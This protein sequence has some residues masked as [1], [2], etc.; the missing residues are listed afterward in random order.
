MIKKVL[1]ANRGEIAVRIIRACKEMS[2]K[3]V[4]VYSEADREALHV[5]LAD[6]SYCI[7]PTASKDSYLNMANLISVA[8]LTQSDAIHP[9]YGFLSENPDFAEICEECNITFIGPSP[10]AIH[11]MGAKAVARETM[12]K[13]GVPTVPG[14]EGLIN[15]PED[16]LRVA[17]E[18]GYPVI[19]K[20][21]AGGGGKGMRQAYDEEELIKA[22][23][24]AQNEA[25]TAFGNSGVYLEKYL[26]EPRHVEIQI[27]ADKYGNVVHLGERDC[28]IQRRHQK[29]VEEAPSPALSPELRQQM[30]ESAVKAAKAVNYCGAGTVEFLL[31]KNSD[32]YFM[33][34][35][36]R[37]QVEHPV[38]EM[39]T[40]IDLIKEQLS[41]ASGNELSVKQEDIVI[42][43]W[44][45]ECRINAEN[46]AKNF[47][48]SPGKIK[49]YLPPGGFGVRVDSA[50]YPDYEISPFY[51]SMVAKVIVW[52]KDR[53]EA[54]ERMKRALDEMVIKGIK[55]TIPFHQQLLKHEA[56]IKGDFNTTFLERYDL[57]IEDDKE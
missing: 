43:G 18:I 19:V 37:I 1:I 48:P 56:F 53:Q 10:E 13:A 55:T 12:K 15:R 40:S 3:T 33:E 2:I 28:S 27:M 41:V 16:A 52:G 21:T 29:L 47:M 20:A 4:S 36:T 24:Q 7:G 26:E 45:I 44:A 51:D 38:T 57:R 17:K 46:P 42:N 14:T 11:K 8:T 5:E 25:E 30:G 32:Y 9:G 34:M 31:D 6:E 23:R 54:I 50:I 22:I 39:I 49:T 35:N